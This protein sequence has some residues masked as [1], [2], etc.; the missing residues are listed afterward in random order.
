MQTTFRDHWKRGTANFQTWAPAWRRAALLCLLL[1]A[2]SLPAHPISLISCQALVHRDRLEMKIAVMPEDFLPVYGLYVNSKSR[3]AS[4]DITNSAGKHKK[5]VLDGLIVRDADGNRLEGKVVQTQVPELPAEGMLV[6]DLMST[7]IVYSLE[8]P[9]AKPPTHLSFQHRFGGTAAVIPAMVDLAVTRDGLPPE[10]AVRIP[11]DENVVT[12]AFDWN[13]TS[14]PAPAGDAEEKAREEAQRQQNMGIGSYSATY[15]FVYIKNQEVRVEILMPLLTLETWQPVARANRDFLEVP[16]QAAARAALEGFFTGQNELKI[17]G[18]AV[19][20]KLDRLDFYGV[21]FKDFA[22][23]AEPRR[24]S[25][26]T[27]RVG[28]ILTYSTKGAP[29]HVELTWTLFNGEMLAAPAVIFA[30]DQ[31]TRFTFYPLSPVFK[32]DNPGAP[33]LPAVT[34][35]STGQKS[36]EAVAESLLRNVYRAFDYRSESD[37]YDALAQSVQGDLL[38]DLYLKIKQGLIMQ[39][40]GGAVARVQ[41]VK[42]IQTEP[43]EGKNKN[44]FAERLTWQVEGTVEHW[45]HI[46][47]RVNEYAAEFEIDP[48]GGAWKI[49][50][51]SVSRQSQVRSGVMIRNL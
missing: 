43:T 30:Y 11:G 33:P 49:T 45:G 40:Q 25:A 41:E 29:G 3:V 42:V 10:P 2:P 15:T 24:L 37:I 12:I 14:R 47:T 9:L 22:M 51:M 5:Y 26:W 31:G 13:E 4:A 28:A 35:I 19:K 20:P 23:S 27:A 7:T 46:H 39:E 6:T 8:Y 17:D 48:A 50:A 34:A 18:V 32:W 36:R 16:E 38:A 44:G 21:D 1:A